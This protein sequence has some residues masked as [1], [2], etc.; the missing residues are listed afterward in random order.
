MMAHMNDTLETTEGDA[1]RSDTP[2][3]VVRAGRRGVYAADFISEGWVGV[4]WGEAGALDAGATDCEIE[5]AIERGYGTEREGT[6]RVWS[7]QIKRFFR[8]V[9]V[10]DPVATYDPEQRMFF[11]GTVTSELF[12]K[13]DHDLFRARRVQWTHKVP[14]DRLSTGARNTLGAILTFFRLSDEV[15]AEL[16]A[17]AVP[18]EADV[19][20]ETAREVQPATTP[21]EDEE[22]ILR[23]E[24]LEKADSFI[25]DRIARLGWSD[26]QELVAGILRA[27]GYKTRVADPGPDRGVDVFASPDGLGLQEPRIF[28]EVKH[29]PGSSMGASELRSFIGGRRAGD[30]CL[31]VSTGGFT[32]EARY[33]AERSS[34]PVM[35]IALP[36]L[37]ELV[38]QHYEAVDA[39]TR[40]LVPLRRMYWPVD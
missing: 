19:S 15:S 31:Y 2:I 3:W 21:E 29:R 20:S 40:S 16:R 23:E 26:L 12:S 35:L 30:R 39:T 25:E 36:E 18:L 7:A 37:R 32:R 28:V 14:R 34:I 9:S 33:E 38:T 24:I 27:M 6:K 22:S 8:E 1:L 4:G 10:G 13:A 11:L 5:Q 17:K